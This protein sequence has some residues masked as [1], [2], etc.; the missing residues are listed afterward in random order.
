MVTFQEIIIYLQNIGVAD[1][2]LPFILIF[3]LVFAILEKIK[4]LGEKSRRYNVVI[5]L[6][7]GLI[8][9]IPH[10]L[11]PS[12]ND[13]VNIMNRAFPNVSVFIIAILALFLL[14]GL[15]SSKAIKWGTTAR[16]WLTIVAFIVIFAI[17]TH[18][19]GWWGGGYLPS[20]LYFLNDPSVIALIVIIIVFIIIIAYI[21]GEEKKPEEKTGFSKFIEALGGEE[22]KEK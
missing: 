13:V 6:V 12:P 20:W 15:W 3:T 4:I 8:V 2:L 18:A 11:S 21:T 7:I 10:V 22:G 17:F 9:V 14:I 16:G 19:A 1:V 5:A